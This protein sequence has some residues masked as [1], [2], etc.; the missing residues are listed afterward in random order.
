MESAM[1]ARK[2]MDEQLTAC[3][4]Y[5]SIQR[6]RMKDTHT[7]RLRTWELGTVKGGGGFGLL[8]ELNPY[9]KNCFVLHRKNGIC[10][11]LSL[12]LYAS[13]HIAWVVLRFSPWGNSREA[14]M[15][16]GYIL[17]LCTE[18]A[19]C[20]HWAPANSALTDDRCG[21]VRCLQG[22]SFWGLPLPVPVEVPVAKGKRCVSCSAPKKCTDAP[23]AAGEGPCMAGRR[24]SCRAAQPAGVRPTSY[25]S[26]L[27]RCSMDPIRVRLA[28][29][30]VRALYDAVRACGHAGAVCRHMHS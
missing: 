29:A 15:I 12:A 16:E 23:L 19:E 7:L 21:I 28:T 30:Y 3:V 9:S 25:S 6:G 26:R 18:V 17:L 4:W 22:E 13:R 27:V 20:R 14:M 10:W 24:F 1:H 11:L 8:V 5:A 2:E